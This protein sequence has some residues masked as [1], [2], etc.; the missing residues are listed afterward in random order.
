MKKTILFGLILMMGFLLTA[1]DNE[2]AKPLVTFLE[3]GAVS[4]IPCRM[5]IPV[6]KEIEEEYGDKIEVIFHDV[7]KDKN[8]AAK[9]G[10]RAIPT[11]VFLDEHGKEFHRHIGFYPTVKIKEILDPILNPED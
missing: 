2:K 8:I 7:T 1:E 10:I 9:Y 5:M 6:M 11:Q 3:I 4:C